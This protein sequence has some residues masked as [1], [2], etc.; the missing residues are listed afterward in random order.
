MDTYHIHKAYDGNEALEILDRESIEEN[1]ED[2]SLNADIMA[3]HLAMSKTQLDR[4]IKA[5]TGL[6]PHGLI[7][8]L[9]LKKAAKALLY[10]EKTVSEI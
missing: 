4:K 9:R 2:S 10:S 6:T 7:N 8:N 1:I 3:G 5:L